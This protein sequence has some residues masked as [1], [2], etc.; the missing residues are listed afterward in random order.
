MAA[1]KHSLMKSR[2][3]QTL[4]C[5]LRQKFY[6]W[7]F[8]LIWLILLI[9]QQRFFI[10]RFLTF[11]ILFH[12]K[13]V[14]NV[15]CSWGQ[16][17]LHQ[18]FWQ[19]NIGDLWI[20]APYTQPQRSCRSAWITVCCRAVGFCNYHGDVCLAVEKIFKFVGFRLLE[21]ERRKIDV[22][23]AAELVFVVLLIWS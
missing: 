6:W 10:Q 14:F 23:P 1:I 7:I 22:R 15:F 13:R 20:V 3:P 21:A 11:F 5:I 17:F 9:Y 8:H 12:K 2:R 16:R 18:W 19:Y 4:S